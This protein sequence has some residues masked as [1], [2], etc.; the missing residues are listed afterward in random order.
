MRLRKLWTGSAWAE[1]P[2]YFRDGDFLLSSDIPNNRIMRFV[3][4][5]TGLDGTVSVCRQP[6]TTPTA[7]PATCRAG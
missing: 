7:T 5:H 1:G 6:S 4:D 2:V 3:P